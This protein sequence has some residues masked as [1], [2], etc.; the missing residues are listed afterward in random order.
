MVGLKLNS[1]GWLEELRLCYG[2][3]FMLKACDRG[4]YDA[5]DSAPAKI[6]RGL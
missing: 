2:K 6:W 4:R 1:L 5:K 3:D